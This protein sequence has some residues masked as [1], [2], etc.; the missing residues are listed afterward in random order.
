MN[1]NNNNLYN[2]SITTS[3]T[4]SSASSSSMSING[5]AQTLISNNSSYS[6]SNK[7]PCNKYFILGEEYEGE[8]YYVDNNISNVIATLNVLGEP[9]WIE[10]KKQNYSLSGDMEIFIEERLRQRRREHNINQVVGTD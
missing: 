6:I 5:T 1:N 3:I 7:Y 9:Y 2:G 10:L 8:G 4:S